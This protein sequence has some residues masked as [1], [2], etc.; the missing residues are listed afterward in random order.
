MAIGIGL[1]C[2]DEVAVA[3]EDVDLNSIEVASRTGNGALDCE[4]GR[5]ADIKSGEAARERD[6]SRL[7]DIGDQL[8]AAGVVVE[9]VEHSWG[10]SESQRVVTG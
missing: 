1:G 2:D 3:E 4:L 6:I 7:A 10:V 8:R 5:P 9:A